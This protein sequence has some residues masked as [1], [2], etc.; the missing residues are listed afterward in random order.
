MRINDAATY[1]IASMPKTLG[2]DPSPS[3]A[4]VALT[5]AIST[6]KRHHPEIA[7]LCGGY[8]FS[9]G[10]DE[11]YPLLSMLPINSESTAAAAA[12]SAKVTP[13]S[14]VRAKRLVYGSAANLWTV[15]KA[16]V[17]QW[18]MICGEGEIDLSCFAPAA[19]GECRGL[20]C[21]AGTPMSFAGKNIG[22]ST[23]TLRQLYL[24]CA[25]KAPGC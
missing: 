20:D 1:A 6:L 25:S 24:L 10:N 12:W 23:A 21:A 16:K 19:I 5:G 4:A 8:G 13:E 17:S 18:D 3:D 14:A 22:G 2:N 9:V 11:D 7:H 15:E